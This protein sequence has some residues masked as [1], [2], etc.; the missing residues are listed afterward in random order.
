MRQPQQLSRRGHR[1]QAQLQI[2]ASLRSQLFQQRQP[3]TDPSLV[4]AQELRHFRLRQAVF[5]NQ[6]LDDPRLFQNMN[7]TGPLVQPV[8]GRFRLAI[9]DFQKQHAQT[10]QVDLTRGAEPLV[11]IEQ[12][13]HFLTPTTD[14]RRQLPELAQGGDHRRCHLGRP[15]P[16]TAKTLVE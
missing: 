8:H 16:I 9:V 13:D 3:A 15:Q 1:Q 5:P 11:S 7:A 2:L 14:H 12:A 4:T 6:R 10:R